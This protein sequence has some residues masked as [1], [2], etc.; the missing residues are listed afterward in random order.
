MGTETNKQKQ[1]I[2]KIKES[3]SYLFAE[4]MN[5]RKRLKML[6]SIIIM[7]L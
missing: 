3:T 4:D 2:Q 1:K 7:I 5:F 6:P